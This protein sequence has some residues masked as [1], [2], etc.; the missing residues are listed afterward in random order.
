MVVILVVV[1]AAEGGLS[2]SVMEIT[3]QAVGRFLTAD[4]VGLTGYDVAADDLPP[5]R[6]EGLGHH[7]DDAAAGGLDV[8]GAAAGG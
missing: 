3:E 4:A 5:Q 8:G 1:P 6:G 7:R 2:F